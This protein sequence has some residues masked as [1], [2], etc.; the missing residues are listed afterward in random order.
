MGQFINFQWLCIKDAWQGGWTKAN[1]MGGLLGAGLLWVVLL[2]LSPR[3]REN[4]LIEAPT[5]YWGVAGLT[6]LSAV[7]S[8]I[9]AFFVIFI[10]RCITAP[11]RLYA[12]LKDE[13]IKLQGE[14]EQ[15]HANRAMLTISGPHMFK[16][17]RYKN[18]LRWRMKVH[19]A[20]PAA[21]NNVQIK[22][23]HVNFGPKD[24]TW[25]A[26]YPYPIARMGSTTDAPINPN[27]DESYEI[28]RGWKS[29]AGLFF[30]TIDTRGH[31][32]IQIQPEELWEFLYEATSSNAQTIGFVLRIFIEADEVKMIR[33]N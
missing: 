30:T 31:N 7:G 17:H 19:N 23:K 22:L 8:V 9:L 16:D 29:E 32:Q 18:Q 26:D 20:G 15:L 25:S 24:P 33:V 12:R 11:A 2:Y 4:Q 6:F 27:D 13:K 14:L 21:A 28:I 5:T 3:L 1:E 10:A